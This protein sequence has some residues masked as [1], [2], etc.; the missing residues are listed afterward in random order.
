[1]SEISYLPSIPSFNI[2]D[3]ADI[4]ISII[5]INYDNSIICFKNK[6]NERNTIPNY[7]DVFDYTEN[8]S[9]IFDNSYNSIPLNS[10][11]S[12]KITYKNKIVFNCKIFENSNPKSLSEICNFPFTTEEFRIYNS[13]IYSS[14]I[15][16]SI[17]KDSNIIKVSSTFGIE[18]DRYIEDDW[19]NDIAYVT[20]V[21][22]DNNEVTISEP[23]LETATNITITIH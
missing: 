12:Y 11:N 17:M 19:V 14:I 3:I 20:N 23:S 15:K 4:N 9:L 22:H 18:P 16:G 5:P 8:R 10:S 7:I 21:D 13:T 1:M 6:S 2:D